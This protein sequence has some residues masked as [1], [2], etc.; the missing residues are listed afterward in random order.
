MANVMPS[1]ITPSDTDALLV[2]DVQNDFCPG[3]ALAIK[4][5]DAVVPIINRIAG[6]FR[7]V[8]L[9]Q[10]W[11][12]RRH[13]S[14]ASRHPGRQPFETITVAYGPQVL[15]P[16]HCV[17]GTSG[18]MFHEDLSLPQAELI[19]RKGFRSEVDSYSAFVENDHKTQTGLSSY[20]RERG[21]NRLFLA[22]LAYDICVLYSAL[23]GKQASFDCS[24]IADA[25]RSVDLHGSHAEADKQYAAANIARIDSAAFA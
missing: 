8:I 24:V 22:G 17:Q 3:G 16:D 23:D 13:G 19:L 12:P 10:D 18:A 25:C 1:S 9:T 20:L 4:D 14:F 15:W 2:I 6:T 7:H 11:H 21:L 5:G